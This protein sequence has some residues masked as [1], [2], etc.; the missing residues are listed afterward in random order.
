MWLHIQHLSHPSPPPLLPPPPKKILYESLDI[1]ECTPTVAV[2]K[3]FRVIVVL[4]SYNSMDCTLSKLTYVE[5]THEKWE[6]KWMR[7]TVTQSAASTC[8][9]RTCYRKDIN[10]RARKL[11]T[12]KQA[13]CFAVFARLWLH[14]RQLSLLGKI[15]YQYCHFLPFFVIPTLLASSFSYKNW[16]TISTL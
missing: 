4:Q 13:A 11:P 7:N 9:Y 2:N 16:Q 10:V 12:L 15:F 6:L 1:I 14:F 5:Y 3:C 8:S